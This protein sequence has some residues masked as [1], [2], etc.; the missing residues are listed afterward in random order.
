MYA[1]TGSALALVANLVVFF[2]PRS[3]V[4]L[5]AGVYV[6][7]FNRRNIMVATETSRG[8][9]FVVIGY[10]TLLG[11]P[12]LLLVYSISFL[13]GLLGA[14]FDLASDAFLPLIVAKDQLLSANSVFT[15]T[16]QA[17]NIVGPALAGLAISLL[18]TGVPLLI[19]S[20]SFFLL[21][22]A[23][24]LIRGVATEPPLRTLGW[25]G[26]F[27][28]GLR[29]FKE[30][31]ELIWLASIVAILNF[32]LAGPW[33]VYLLVF[34]KDLLRVGSQGWGLLGA[35]SAAGILVASIIMGRVGKVSRKRG[36][37]TTS[38]VA[39]GLCVI[40]FSFT[41]TLLTSL[42]AVFAIGFTIPFFDVLI[43]TFYQEVVPAPLMGR[44]FGVRHFINYLLI[45]L[46]V[47]FGGVAV[48]YY[49]VSTAILISGVTVLLS[50]VATL[51]VR[52]LSL[53]D[54]K[55]SPNP[56]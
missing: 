43:V 31:R 1:I 16:F 14:L 27:K 49:G 26:E 18:G 9:L 12:P 25:L 39:L 15:A 4:R 54:E 17:G 36:L 28:E 50:G 56:S 5:Y 32:G 35:A 2:L 23:L 7:R 29:F 30:R 40:L 21:V 22:G 37:L 3:A 42:F 24:F 34:A 46:G 8:V 51:F 20:S 41:N 55:P 10:V 45:P 6:D 19:D 53:L 52:S 11:S 33:N 47:L 38:V 48:V 13:V 44:V